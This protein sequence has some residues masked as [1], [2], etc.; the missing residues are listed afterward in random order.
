MENEFNYSSDDDVESPLKLSISTFSSSP[1]SSPSL[2]LTLSPYNN[3]SPYTKLSTDDYR[4]NDS[5]SNH[6]IDHIFN[7]VAKFPFSIGLVLLLFIIY[8]IQFN[9]NLLDN[10][11]LRLGMIS[12]WDECDDNRLLIWKFFTSVVLHVSSE[13]FWGNFVISIIYS[14]LLE[15]YQSILVIVPGTITII[16][17]TNLAFYYIRPYEEA[18][19]FSGVVFGL[20]GMSISSVLINIDYF[21]FI[22]T[23]G[24]LVFS[25]FLVCTE[26]ASYNKDQN[27]AYICHWVGI[28]TGF[29]IG[30]P[31]FKRYNYSGNKI[32]YTNIILSAVIIYSSITTIFTYNYIINWPPLQQ[33][34]NV[35][36]KIET[37]NCCYEWYKY[38]NYK[39]D[40][41][42]SQFT[43]PYQ[44]NYNQINQFHI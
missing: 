18:M 34:N 13:H 28:I 4:I 9:S 16:F 21:P 26:A 38:S 3:T 14:V 19:G 1:Q 11:E 27:I 24:T 30:W 22:Y 29:L 31:L 25:L 6:C 10:H 40:V 15:S 2:S 37:Y 35:F 12:R 5:V 23:L 39:T 41:D 17:N 44:I 33:Y 7:F 32:I 42:I 36:K 43:C 8:I 20:I